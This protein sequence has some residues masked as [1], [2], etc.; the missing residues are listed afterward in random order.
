[1]ILSINGRD[2]NL[3]FGLAFLREINKLHSAEL[4]GYGA[5]TLISAGVAINDPLAFVDIIK[6]GTITAPQKPS[7]A[8]IE[9]YLADLIDKGKYKETIDSIID[10]L[11]A[12][13]LLKL[14]MNVQ[15]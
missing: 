6:A 3:I 2:Y 4:E 15:E 9:A 11:K 1:M 8:D 12:S 5:M 14:A 7:D 10:E 13:S